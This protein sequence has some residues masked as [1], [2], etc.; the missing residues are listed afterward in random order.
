MIDAVSRL[1]TFSFLWPNMLWLLALALVLVLGYLW[2][3][4]R[5]Q[6]AGAAQ[7]HLP[8]AYTHAVRKPE[9]RRHVGPLLALSALIAGKAVSQKIADA[10]HLLEL[11]NEGRLPQPPVRPWRLAETPFLDRLRVSVGA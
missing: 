2:L 6:R 11:M 9:W 1:P 8:P 7:P 3:D 5:R 4:W 10:R